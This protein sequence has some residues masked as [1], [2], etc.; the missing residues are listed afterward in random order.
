LYIWHMGTGNTGRALVLVLGL[1]SWVVNTCTLTLH[2]NKRLSELLVLLTAQQSGPP[3]PPSYSS[4]CPSQAGRCCPG[5]WRSRRHEWLG[6][7]LSLRIWR[8]RSLF[9][10]RCTSVWGF[11]P[12]A[13][14]CTWHR[15]CRG[16]S[17]KSITSTLE[18][19]AY[20]QALS[21]VDVPPCH[22]HQVH[23]QNTNT[24]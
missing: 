7:L 10:S 21:G 14:R 12:P 3:L 1:G 22:I 11:S 19:A 18:P 4:A 9:D 24:G 6:V 15:I 23:F 8:L 5:D 16:S 17:I 13:R 20:V 2:S